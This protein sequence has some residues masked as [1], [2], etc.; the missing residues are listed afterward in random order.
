M[1]T[2]ITL[3]D[4]DAMVMCLVLLGCQSCGCKGKNG[5]EMKIR[6]RPWQ[7]QEPWDGAQ[8]L[9]HEI[10]G[11]EQYQSDGQMDNM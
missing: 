4:V 7:C 11:L 2:H 1:S 9:W 10:T 6:L 8:Q 3:K 5:S